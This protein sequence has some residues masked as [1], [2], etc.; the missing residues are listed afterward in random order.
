VTSP[1]GLRLID[2]ED[3]GSRP[4]DP[5]VLVRTIPTPPGLPWDQARAARLEAVHGAPLP[6]ADIVF[7]L[8]RLDPWRPGAPGRYVAF[9]VL[10]RELTGR[11]DTT[12]EVDGRILPV[13]FLTPAQQ[14]VQARRVLTIGVAAGLAV[15][16]VTASVGAAFAKRSQA[17]A[18]LSALET[19]AATRLRAVEVR[20]KLKTQNRA[21]EAQPDRGGRI[22]DALS[23]I[24][25]AS[26][27]KSPEAHIEQLHWEPGLLAVEVRGTPAPFGANEDRAVQKAAKP[28]RHGVWLW[29]VTR[30]A[31]ASAIHAPI[32]AVPLD[33]PLGTTR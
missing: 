7:R 20:Q 16:V 18:T 25:W 5:K 17:E 19:R 6:M 3:A 15:F 1:G 27:A 13:S 14:R 9:Y 32:A 11:L 21:L 23:D 30:R 33:Q 10:A 22:R 26:A 4:P 29:G 12:V 2:E 8:Q 28:V 31:I 24:A